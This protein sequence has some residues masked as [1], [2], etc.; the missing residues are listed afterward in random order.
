VLVHVSGQDVGPYWNRKGQITQ[1]I[2]AAYKFDLQFCYILAGWEGLAYD[3]KVLNDAFDKGFVIPEGKYYLC[4][5]GYV[6]KKGCLTPYGGL[7]Y[8]LREQY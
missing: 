2:M 8:H 1:N 4:D 5:A 6:L 3:G 7:R